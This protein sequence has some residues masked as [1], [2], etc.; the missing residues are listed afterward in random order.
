[1]WESLEA[2]RTRVLERELRVDLAEYERTV[3][4]PMPAEWHREELRDPTL[5]LAEE[6][7]DYRDLRYAIRAMSL[8]AQDAGLDIDR[9]SNMIGG[10]YA[11]E[12]PGMEVMVR[13]MLSMP[14]EALMVD[15][16]Q[17]YPFV[18]KHFY[19]THSFFYV[20]VLGK[21]LGLHGFSTCIHNA[22][23]SGAFALELAAQQ[24]RSG[25]AP[26]MLVA[27]AEAFET[28]VRVRYLKGMDSYV[29]GPEMR[30]FDAAPTGFYVGEGGAALVLEARSHAEARGVPI[31]A[32]YLGGGFAQQ[33]WKHMI[34]DVP[35]NR[36]ASAAKKALGEAG[37]SP[38]EVDL[39]VPHGAGSAVSDGYEAH[40][41]GQIFDE[42]SPA[43]LCPLKPYLGHQLGNCVIVELAASLLMMREGVVL[44]QPFDMQPNGR[45][46]LE[47]PQ[48]NRP[49]SSQILMKLATGFTGHDA[50]LLFRRG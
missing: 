13:H 1:M 8:A 50:V 12:A 18:S 39:V 19:H 5:L 2:N 41:L 23:S 26:V 31:Y 17:L 29:Q 35:A 37:V 32:E 10:I 11:F 46:P 28:G 9:E 15:Q 44:G 48:S 16:P 25:A 34:C 42:H 27:G 47:I 36:L 45:V 33:S 7:A 49:H 21:A 22:C 40:S 14:P 30:A 43:L 24:I 4:S 3:L 38:V 6:C 20:H